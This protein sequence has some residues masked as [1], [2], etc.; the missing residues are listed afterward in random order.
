MAASAPIL[1]TK[2]YIPPPP[3]KVVVRTRLIKRLDDD[4]YL[5][6]VT[7]RKPTSKWSDLNRRR[8]AELNAAGLLEAA[9]KA[10]APTSNVYAQKPQIPELP[11]FVTQA[12]KANPKAWSFFQSL[13]PTYRR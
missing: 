4:R 6:K 12:I 2:L 10:A 7:P 5:R 8:W 3:P 11:D 1:T 13:S 9:G